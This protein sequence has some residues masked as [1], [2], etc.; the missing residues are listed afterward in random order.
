MVSNKKKDRLTG[1]FP[2]YELGTNMGR[3]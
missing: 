3:Q 1:H 2:E